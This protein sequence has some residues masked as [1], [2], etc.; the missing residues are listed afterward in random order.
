MIAVVGISPEL[1][2]EE[3]D[4]NAPGFFGGD[5]VDLKLPEP[6]EELLRRSRRR[7]SR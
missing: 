3:A 2:N 7:A 1:E 5:R 4:V 6:Q